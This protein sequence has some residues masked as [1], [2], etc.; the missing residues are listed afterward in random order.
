MWRSRG[1]VTDHAGTEALN[2][3]EERPWNV[4]MYV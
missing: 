1:T 4:T 3:N 2:L